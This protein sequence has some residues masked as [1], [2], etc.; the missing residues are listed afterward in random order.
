MRENCVR[1]N[2]TSFVAPVPGTEPAPDQPV[3]TCR[4][5][6]AVTTTLST[7]AVVIWLV[8]KSLSPTGGS[9]LP[10]AEE[11]STPSPLTFRTLTQST[12]V[13]SSGAVVSGRLL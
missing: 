12:A 6:G 11:T 9:G 10:Y 5:P 13:P 8:G 2:T 3:D 7:R 4:T 1:V